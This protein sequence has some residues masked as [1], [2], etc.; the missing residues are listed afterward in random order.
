MGCIYTAISRKARTYGEF[1][2]GQTKKTYPTSR[3]NAN[4]LE[5]IYFIQCPKAT[6]SQLLLLESVARCACENISSLVKSCGDDWF[7]YIITDGRHFSKM[8]Q[9]ETFAITVMDEVIEE[10]KRRNIQYIL[11]TC[12]KNGHH[13]SCATAPEIKK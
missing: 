6:A 7:S 12:F 3:Y 11:R 4:D 2:I 10:C 13:Y 1:K 8:E 9:A 5:G